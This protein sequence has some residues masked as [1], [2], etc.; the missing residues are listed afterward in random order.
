M[1]LNLITGIQNLIKTGNNTLQNVQ[2]IAGYDT[3]QSAITEGY[4]VKNGTFVFLTE[5]GMSLTKPLES[6]NFNDGQL[7]CS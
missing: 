3:I 5:K 4:I 2:S 6:N 1:D 7:I